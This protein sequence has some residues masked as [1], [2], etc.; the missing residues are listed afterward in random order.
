MFPQELNPSADAAHSG[1][2]E[3]F[4]EKL[5]QPESWTSVAKSRR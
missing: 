1:T 5:F 3:Q 2:A 4:A